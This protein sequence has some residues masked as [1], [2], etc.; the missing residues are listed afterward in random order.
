MQAR[1]LPHVKLDQHDM[2]PRVK[3]KDHTIIPTDAEK[4][5]DKILTFMIKALKKLEIGGKSLNL[6]NGIY[7]KL[8]PDDE[9][10]YTFS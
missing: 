6:I 2:S 4:V 7:E 8:L 9:R 1:T 10:L 3:E 5:F